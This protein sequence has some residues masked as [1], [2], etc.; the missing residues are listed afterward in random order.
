MKTKKQLVWG[1]L[2]VLA[3]SALL[4]A[5]STMQDNTEQEK[6]NLAVNRQLYEAA[7]NK[8]DFAAV[9]KLLAP[10]VVEHEELPGLPPTRD[11]VIQFFK[12]FRQAFPD[13]HANI[14]FAIA[15]DDRVVSYVTMTG[16]NKGEF[17][18]MP[19]TGKKIEFR[20]IDIIRYKDGMAV[21]HWGL[22]DDLTMMQQL[23][24]IPVPGEASKK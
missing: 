5:F 20:V 12:M 6:K 14:E 19:A 13:L 10:D 7:F 16:T 1:T 21:E 24:V 11:G 15:K 3:L 4:M 23:G 8:G 2:A 9:K 17:M 18:G 22:A